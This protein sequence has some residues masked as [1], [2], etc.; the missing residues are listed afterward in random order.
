MITWKTWD[1]NMAHG[2]QTEWWWITHLPA[3]SVTHGDLRPKRTVMDVSI[4][5]AVGNDFK[6]GL[7]GVEKHAAGTGKQANAVRRLAGR[8]W[9]TAAG[10]EPDHRPDP[11]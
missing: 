7:C 6:S 4:V 5:V 8:I 2:T 9:I 1:W 3:K 11:Y 10:I